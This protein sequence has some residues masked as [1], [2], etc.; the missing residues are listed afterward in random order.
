MT[1]LPLSLS[2][3]FILLCAGLAGQSIQAADTSDKISNEATVAL[4]K[5]D[6]EFV[7]TALSGGWSS[8]KAAELGL[9]RGLV[10]AEHDFAQKVLDEHTKLTDELKAIAKVKGIV[11]PSML[12]EKSQSKVDDLGKKNDVEFPLAF[13][14]FQMDAHKQAVS[15]FKDA[16]EDAKDI[17]VKVFAIKYLATLQAH[18]EKAKELTKKR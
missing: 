4:N 6:T 5:A 10:G 9:K 8:E 13:L 15:A 1:R 12:D 11:V 18:L 2:F 3:S 7:H 17:D 16:S 14:Q